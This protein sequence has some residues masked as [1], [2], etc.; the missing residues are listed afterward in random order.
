MFLPILL[1]LY[2]IISC[3]IMQLNLLITLFLKVL[4]YIVC[5][6]SAIIVILLFIFGKWIVVYVCTEVNFDLLPC[7]QSAP[8]CKVLKI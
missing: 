4:F 6:C 5:V 3:L 7:Q 8:L 1:S 2:C